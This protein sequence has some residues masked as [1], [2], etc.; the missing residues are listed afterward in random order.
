M[1]RPG[2]RT[3]QGEWR[4]RRGPVACSCLR[5]KR[6]RSEH[7]S[8]KF[9]TRSPASMFPASAGCVV[10]L[11]VPSSTMSGGSSR[12]LP[13]HEPFSSRNLVS[14]RT[15]VVHIH[16][17]RKQNGSRPFALVDWNS[18]SDHPTHLAFRRAALADRPTRKTA[19]GADCGASCS[20]HGILYLRCDIAYSHLR[21]RS[22]GGVD[23]DSFRTLLRS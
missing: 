14:R 16:L 12:R 18:P 19:G 1:R 8:L 3:T 6:Q 10:W 22:A 9:R 21:L 5:R 15:F 20:F 23:S 7:A 11:A 17:R 4:A 13:M 2:Q